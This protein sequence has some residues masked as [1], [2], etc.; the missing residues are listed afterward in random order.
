MCVKTLDFA[1]APGGAHL[2]FYWTMDEGGAAAKLDSTV[3]LPWALAFTTVAAPG[4]FSN[5]THCAPGAFEGEGLSLLGSMLM[6]LNGTTSTGISSWYWFKVNAF[7]TAVTFLQCYYSA[8]DSVGPQQSQ[9]VYWWNCS[10]PVT[11]GFHI[12]HRDDTLPI[13]FI[14]GA[15]PP[16]ALGTWHMIAATI[17]TTAHT[18][19]FYFDGV[20]LATVADTTPL[21]TCDTADIE[22]RNAIQPF[23]N[24]DVVVDECG[25]SLK[26]ALS[27]PQVAALYNSGAG[28][29]WPNITPIV[30]YP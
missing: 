6:P 27:G 21:H 30:P 19:N 8:Y 2:S 1:A 9:L 20:L 26:G 5:G 4:L 13:V 14:N 17:D 22:L 12:D 24:M 23:G 7:Q 10:D 16:V 3:G 18:L 25:L 11:G 29:T 15:L 28:V